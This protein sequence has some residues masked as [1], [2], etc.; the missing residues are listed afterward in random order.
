ALAYRC[1]ALGGAPRMM[2]RLLVGNAPAILTYHAV[3]ADPLEVPDW[4]FLDARRFREQLRYLKQ[5]FNIIRLREIP[6]ALRAPDHRPTVALTF[7]DGFRNNRTVA[8]PILR[9]LELPA[10][11]FL[12]TD[13]VSSEDAPWFCRIHDAVATTTLR[14][15]VREGETFDLSSPRTRAIANAR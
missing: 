7:D 6:A 11:I 8:F 3:T 14:E 5:H 10:T 4:C 9:E 12:T 15:L 2:Q 1:G 13:F